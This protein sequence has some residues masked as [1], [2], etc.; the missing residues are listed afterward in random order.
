MEKVLNQNV[1]TRA[2]DKIDIYFQ[3][4]ERDS[5]LKREILGGFTTILTISYVNFVITTIHA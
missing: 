1:K 2:Y 5:S 4:S 3:I